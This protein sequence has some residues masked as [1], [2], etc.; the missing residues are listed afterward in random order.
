MLPS[1]LQQCDGWYLSGKQLQQRL[2]AKGRLPSV[3]SKVSVENDSRGE[4]YGT[5]TVP[6]ISMAI[7]SHAEVCW[8][9]ESQ[10]NTWPVLSPSCKW[11]QSF[12]PFHCFPSHSFHSLLL[13]WSNIQLEWMDVKIALK[14]AKMRVSGKVT[15]LLIEIDSQKW[16]LL[17]FL[18]AVLST[19]FSS[20]S[21]SL[22]S[23]CV[24]C[25]ASIFS[26]F[27]SPLL[28][29]IKSDNP[30]TEQWQSRLW[31]REMKSSSSSWTGHRSVIIDS[32]L[33]EA[34]FA[35]M[36]FISGDIYCHPWMQEMV[37]CGRN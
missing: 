28:F 27:D 18:L 36:S 6:M 3:R 31:D 10:L 26:L 24:K 30:Q 34:S 23:Q 8:K 7:A 17:P 22:C 12:V 32:D 20:Q 14:A 19:F 5:L 9:K 15:P 35:D 25:T 1:I 16:R 29:P 4:T 37:S 2:S 11:C 21:D 33:R 13:L